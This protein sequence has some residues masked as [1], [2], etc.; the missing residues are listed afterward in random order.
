M[1]RLLLPVLALAGVAA[2]IGGAAAPPPSPPPLASLPA[3][4]APPGNPMSAER[5]ALGRL[6]F[7]DARLSGDGSTSCASC[8]VP[9][10]GWTHND[11]LA[12]GYPGHR[13]WRNNPTVLNC[14]HHTR[15][16]WD[17]SLD[18]LEAQAQAAMQ[19]PVEGNGSA[20]MVEARLAF[21]PDY[22]ERFRA[23]FGD[24][25]PRLEH[26][27]QAIAAFERT[28]VSDPGQVPFDRYLAGDRTAL[29][30]PAQRGL[31]LFTGKAG[32]LQCHHGALLT[33]EGFHALGVP[34][35]AQFDSHPLVQIAV[36]WQNAQRD[37]PSAVLRGH[38]EDLGRYYVTRDVADI[39]KFRTPTL[40]ELKY[41]GPYMHNGAFTTLR[42]VVDF[43][44]A[45][46]GAVA[47]KSPLMKPLGLSEGEKGDLVAFLES[48]SMD[49]P[50]IV[51]AP[52]LP[53][54]RSSAAAAEQ[55]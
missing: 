8:H 34:R 36:R 6:L 48:L 23:V 20:A 37:V 16:M 35:Q 14:A 21:V 28:L 49:R 4:T 19:A 43:F 22:V 54:L 24:E 50:L 44:D 13:L 11:P 15:L 25:T 38:D 32:C 7:F 40:R 17:G 30:A 31:A 52:A 18:S 41:T 51:E 2:L 45:G 12:K 27:W 5:I 46:G 9:Q 3:V 10:L 26:V 42:E 1:K 55:R 33:D 29:T 39:G 47:N 53:P